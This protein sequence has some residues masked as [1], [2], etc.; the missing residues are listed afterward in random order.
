VGSTIFPDYQWSGGGYT[1]TLTM[2]REYGLGAANALPAYSFNYEDDMHL[3]SATNGYGGTVTFTYDNWHETIPYAGWGNNV[4]DNGVPALGNP[5]KYHFSNSADG[6]MKS[7]TTSTLTYDEG[8]NGSIIVV[9]TAQ[10]AGVKSFQPGRW[11][12]IVAS[13]RAVDSYGTHEAQL[14]FNY[15]QN[16]TA[17][18]FYGNATAVNTTQFKTIASGP[19]FLPVDATSLKP[20]IVSTGS[21]RVNWYYLYPLP[22]AYRVTERMLSTSSDSYSF[23]YAYTGAATNNPSLSDAAAGTHPYINPYTEFRGH[24]QV[25]ETDPYGKKTITEYNQSDC[26]GGRPSRTTLKQGTRIMEV[27]SLTYAC[28]AWNT[29]LTLYDV[30]MHKNFY[31]LYTWDDVKYDKL[32]Y[33]WVRTVSESRDVYGGSPN[34]VAASLLTEYGYDPAYG[35][36]TQ[37]TVSGTDIA[38]TTTTTDYFPNASA[39]VWLVGLPARTTVTNAGG[40]VLSRTLNLYD[41]H[42]NYTNL[43]TVGILTGTRTLMRGTQYSQ[44]SYVRDAWGN[45]IEQMTWT[46]YGTASADPTDGAQSTYTCYGTGQSIGGKWCANDGYHTYPL[47]TKNAKGHISTIKYDYNQDSINDYI[48]GV[49]T[50]ETD[51]N[52]AVTTVTYDVFGRFKS[53]T[54]PGDSTPS[55]N[56]TYVN[57][58]FKVTLTQEID[59]GLTYTVVRN[60]DGMGRQTSSVTGGVT[61]LYQYGNEN[62]PLTPRVDKVSMPGSSSDFTATKYDALG[63]PLNV[64]A[65]D[66]TSTTYAY[67]GLMTTV[68]D[69]KNH[70]TTSVSN[71]LG[72]TLSVTPPT[73]P[74]VDYTYDDLGNLLSATRG[75]AAVTLA[76]D[77]AGRKTSMDD[78]DMGGW[79]YTYDALGNMLTQTDA[80]G[81]VLTMMYDELNRLDTKTSSGSCGGHPSSQISVDYDYDSTTDGNKGIGR[82]TSMGVSGGDFTSWFYDI[83]G[84]VEREAKQILPNGGQYV[85]RFTYNSA[86]LPK[87]MTYPDNEVVT[88]NYN[89]RMLVEK[90]F[91]D[92]GTPGNLADDI[93]YAQSI[94]YDSASRMVEIIRGENKI[95]TDYTYNAWNADGGR[96]LSI[97]STQVSNSTL[98]QGL[99]YDYDSVGN[100]NTIVDNVRKN[101]FD[102]PQ[103]QCFQYDELDRLLQ[104]TASYQDASQGCT[105]Q[106]G[107]GNYNEGYAYDGTTGNLAS[108]GTVNYTAYDANHKHAVTTLSNGNTYG[109]DENGNMTSRNVGGQINTL[110]YDAENRLISVSGAATASFSYDADGKQ[111][112]GTVNGV[113]TYYVGNHYE[114][115]NDVVTKYYFAGAT[116]LA[117]RTGETLSYLLADHIGSSSVTTDANGGYSAQ[118]LYKAFGESRHTDGTLGTDYKFTGQRSEA[119]LGIYFFQS[120]WFDPSLG[121]FT[122][123]DTIVPTQTQ[124]TQAWDRYAFVN[125]NP[126]RYIDPTGH[127]VDCGL[128][129]SYCTVGYY[130]PVALIAIYH[131]NYDDFDFVNG[132][133]V[134]E[135]EN[136][137]IDD[138]LNTHPDYHPNDDPYLES[139]LAFKE[140]RIA[141]WQKRLADSGVCTS[142][143]FCYDEAVKLFMYYDEHQFVRGPEVWDSSKVSWPSVTL[144][145]VGI[146]LSLVGV[147]RLNPSTPLG[148]NLLR[149]AGFADSTASL[150]TIDNPMEGIMALGS[151]VPIAGAFFDV[152]ILISDLSDGRYYLPYNPPIP[153]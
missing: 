32:K 35:N 112:I 44:V 66:G 62:G 109:Y 28:S 14:G 125:N 151:Y 145:I 12:M 111:V 133:G 94:A 80:R 15:T 20:R 78:P 119:A 113:T 117:V 57:N 97:T 36:L 2:V 72:W 60:Y 129:D 17:H 115:K 69:A 46:G 26:L 87:T 84:R 134:A 70:S 148:S 101:E 11:Y 106:A 30:E 103:K 131:S 16:G 104:S 102:D 71:I 89:Y 83:R 108:K 90:V 136:Q 105:V 107:V 31:P 33:R 42:N 52:G 95:H 75:G 7:G 76:Y 43:P 51:P 142:F 49:P 132:S 93:N 8:G 73:G 63:R 88:F 121:R 126:V 54:R 135:Q 99:T 40:T 65:P 124:G 45:A 152:Y 116:R 19:L 18:A 140:H 153:R 47:W 141:Y 149:W 77:K 1:P 27:S 110:M 34:G 3:T 114:K 55:L 146:P 10:A 118:E 150:A 137:E 64:S 85:T 59:T 24:S 67:N 41:N 23:T 79:S 50:S 53:L 123:P 100:I 96:L 92:N 74:G 143:F 128:G 25:I 56:V 39:T 48:L 4:P 138:F 144:D 122:Q 147:G 37:K 120:R 127:S 81:C 58:P 86:D 21:N 38:T 91:N 98:L 139:T 68:T 29:S 13:V 22:T 82:R 6:W 9:G 5:Q 61:T 130:S